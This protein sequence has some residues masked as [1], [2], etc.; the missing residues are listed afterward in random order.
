MA[1]DTKRQVME[2]E[3]GVI[4]CESHLDLIKNWAQFCLSFPINLEYILEIFDSV[5]LI[6]TSTHSS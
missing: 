6:T 2:V 5:L 1:E 3:E 4:K